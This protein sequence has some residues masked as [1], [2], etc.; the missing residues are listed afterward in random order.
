MRGDE[1]GEGK[2]A[3]EKTKLK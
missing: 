3:D 2:N 1:D